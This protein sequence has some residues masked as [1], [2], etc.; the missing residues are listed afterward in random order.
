MTESV[1]CDIVK[2]RMEAKGLF[3]LALITKMITEVEVVRVRIT[4]ACTECKQRNY[5]MTK[6]KKTHPERM[7]TKKYCRFCKTH[8]LHKETK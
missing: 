4:L 8:T 6:D 2:K 5:N 7:E 1:A 3:F